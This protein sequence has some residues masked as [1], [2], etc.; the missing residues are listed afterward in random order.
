M[1]NQA[2]RHEDVWASGGI[3]S[4]ILILD[5]R[6]GN[7]WSTWRSGSFYSRGKSPWYIL[8]RRISYL[9]RAPAAIHTAGVVPNASSAV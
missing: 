1:I 2:P 4:H 3:I 9:Y 6:D 5:T 7:E 8:E